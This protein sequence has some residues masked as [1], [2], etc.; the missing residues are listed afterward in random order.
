MS[1]SDGTTTLQRRWGV[2]GVIASH[3][4]GRLSRRSEPRHHHT[5]QQ[6]HQDEHARPG[7]ARS[8]HQRSNAPRQQRLLRSSPA[9]SPR[10]PAD[11]PKPSAAPHR[12]MRWSGRD[13]SHA[14][15]GNGSGQRRHGVGDRTAFSVDE[16]RAVRLR[17]LSDAR[18]VGSRRRNWSR[19]IGWAEEGEHLP[20]PSEAQSYPILAV[21]EA[22]YR[23]RRGGRFL[24]C[25]RSAAKASSHA[26][27]KRSPP[28][29]KA[30][31][32]RT[33]NPRNATVRTKHGTTSA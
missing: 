4:L 13:A 30:A 9:S 10:P 11:T 19:G 16:H 23:W 33:V 32:S 14:P 12:A 29:I 3:H 18:A 17:D 5:D 8:K 2:V 6:R 31:V 1:T 28:K 24:G 25:V 21:W 7:R 20:T 22:Q 26:P 15:G 27:P